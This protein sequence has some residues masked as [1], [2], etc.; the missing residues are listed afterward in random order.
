MMNNLPLVSEHDSGTVITSAIP[1]NFVYPGLSM[2]QIL[3]IAKAKRKLSLLIVLT[4]ML[5]TFL[6]LTFWPRTY[7]AT[8]TLMVNYEVNDPLNDKELPVGQVSS[9]IATQ[10]ELMQI[11]EVLLIVVDQLNLTQNKE[12]SRGYPGNGGTLR[13]WVVTKL[14]KNL[15]IYQGQMGSQLIYVTYS[16]NDANEAALVANMVAEVYLTSIVKRSLQSQLAGQ[17]AR[18]AKLK[19]AFGPRHPDVMELQSQI[20]STR[21]RLVTQATIKPLTD[22]SETTSQ[23]ALPAEYKFSS[24]GHKT[25]VSIISRAIPPVKATKPKISSGFLL[26]GLIA[27]LLGLGVPLSYELFNRR[28]R[29][30]DDI[31]RQHGIPVLVEFAALPKHITTLSMRSST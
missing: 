10:V 23:E 28:V 5:L 17:Q 2:A 29:C 15:V 3:S 19:I 13:E 1:L 11:P 20:E 25:N 9:Y 14:S 6:I 4:V 7:V 30:R 21:N 24:S 18:M 26:G 22:S 8:M 16:A 31:E 12:Y 27:G